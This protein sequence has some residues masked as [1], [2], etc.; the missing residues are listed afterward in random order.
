MLQELKIAREEIGK[1]QE[2][3]AASQENKQE[4]T[5]EDEIFETKGTAAQQQTPV[6]WPLLPYQ[7][8]KQQNK[9]TFTLM[10]QCMKNYNSLKKW[11]EYHVLV[12]VY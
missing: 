10:S 5:E 12:F 1:V 9:K 8:S 7:P 4:M 2:M 11:P 6:G 3:L